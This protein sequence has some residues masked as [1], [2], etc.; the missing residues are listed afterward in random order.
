MS[1]KL[2]RQCL[3]RTSKKRERTARVKCGE[4]S[5]GALFFFLK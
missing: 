4:S 3:E 5:A 2:L 1:G